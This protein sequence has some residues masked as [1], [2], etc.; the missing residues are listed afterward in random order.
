MCWWSLSIAVKR[1][2]RP[3]PVD[4]CLLSQHMKANARKVSMCF[5]I[6]NRQVLQC[7]TFALEPSRI[8]YFDD[9]RSLS[10]IHT[11]GCSRKSWTVTNDQ[12][13]NSK[14]SIDAVYSVY[15]MSRCLKRYIAVSLSVLT[16][17]HLSN[18]TCQ[19]SQEYPLNLNISVSGVKRN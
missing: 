11:T 7:G 8:K 17:S 10:D 15:D 16:D 13:V 9:W 14:W 6:S 18:V 12:F 4:R 19:L 1:A 5:E 3:I 2:H